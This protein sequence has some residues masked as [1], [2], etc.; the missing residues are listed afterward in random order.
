MELY[1]DLESNCS[2]L[3]K[4]ILALVPTKVHFIKKEIES[5]DLKIDPSLHPYIFIS[6][7]IPSS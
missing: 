3:A 1:P 4:H 5:I 7:I 2:D 6:K